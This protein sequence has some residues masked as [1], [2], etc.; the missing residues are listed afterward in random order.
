M[1]TKMNPSAVAPY[2]QCFVMDA[3][4]NDRA[5]E[6]CLPFFE[7]KSHFFKKKKRVGEVQ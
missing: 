6:T 1:G 2:Q 5:G 7:Q 3:S 4:K